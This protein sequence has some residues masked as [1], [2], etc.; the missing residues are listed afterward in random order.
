MDLLLGRNDETLDGFFDGFRSDGLAVG[1]F[2][3][4]LLGGALD[5]FFVGFFKGFLL[6]RKDGPLEGFLVGIELGISKVKRKEI[7]YPDETI[8]E[9]LT[10]VFLTPADVLQNP[11]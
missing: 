7:L 5:G 10:K 6:G 4:F 8:F 1:F 3:G 9:I 2:D 11:Q